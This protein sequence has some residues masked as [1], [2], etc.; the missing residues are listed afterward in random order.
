MKLMKRTGGI[1]SAMALCSLV[2]MP[3]ACDDYVQQYDPQKPEEVIPEVEKVEKSFT[4]NVDVPSVKTTISDGENNTKIVAWEAGDEFNVYWGPAEQD[5]G[6]ASTTT[7][8]ASATFKAQVAETDNY[9]AV[10]P[11]TVSAVFAETGKVNVTVPAVQDGSFAAAGVMAA[12]TGKDAMAFDFENV[13]AIIKFTVQKENVGQVV[14]KAKEAIGGVVE[15][16]FGSGAPAVSVSGDKDMVTFPSASVGAA[17]TPGDYYICVAPVAL[18][19]GLTVT[20]VTTEGSV[21][22][23][24]TI[25]TVAALE[26]SWLYDLG[27]VDNVDPASITEYFVT[28]EGK[29]AKSGADWAN[30]MSEADL[31]E[32]LKADPETVTDRGKALNGKKIHLAEGKYVMSED[33][34]KYFP[35]NYAGFAVPVEVE[36]IGGYSASDPQQRDPAK[37]PTVFSGDKKYAGFVIGDNVDFTF[38]GVTFADAVATT[39]PDLIQTTRA[40]VFVN[41]PSATLSFNDCM[42]KDNVQSGISKT[43]YEGGAAICLIKGYV[44]ADGC[45]FV[46]NVSGSR[47][48]AVRVDDKNDKGGLC[49]LNDCMFTGN[50]IDRDSYGM[51]I[52]ARN[53]IAINKCV[54]IN[55]EAADASKNNPS[56]NFNHNYVMINSIVIEDSFFSSGT[57]T[58]RTETETKNGVT[59]ALMNNVIVNSHPAD[60]NNKAW[61][62]LASK[63][64]GVV[65]KGYNLLYGKD[66]GISHPDRLP[67]HSTDLTAESAPTYTFDPNTYELKMSDLGFTFAD[68]AAVEAMLRGTDMVATAGV[69]TYAADFANW[70][71]SINAL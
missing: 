21:L 5:L 31:R 59:A 33:A 41:S 57:G 56:L 65:S 39:D 26:R 44:Y 4:A 2:F 36:F 48:A 14:F 19:D 66:A 45:K 58:V 49:F 69:T 50:R 32:L 18:A 63:T 25:E 68:N 60:E 22:A 46:G 53:N 61:A 10:Y 11:T 7:G 42:F 15:M 71:K 37:T 3:V 62:I 64:N 51:A 9:A 16:T 28:V 12:V 35:V 29:G 6:V 8:G 70:L 54:F 20:A 52:F 47:G 30:A 13:G 34:L 38:D 23:M 43:D 40:A 24:N 67:A 17:V 1:L 55:N 27:P